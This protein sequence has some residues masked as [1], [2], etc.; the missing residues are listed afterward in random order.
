M[1]HIYFI[2][3][4]EIFL[5]FLL[6][7]YIYICLTVLRSLKMRLVYS[8]LSKQRVNKTKISNYFSDGSNIIKLTYLTFKIW[9]STHQS[10][11]YPYVFMSVNEHCCWDNI[12]GQIS[13]VD[14]MEINARISSLIVHMLT[15]S[16]MKQSK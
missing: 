10:C 12:L 11:S 13:K 6:L 14:R 9:S 3:K 2:Q 16:S 8:F 5:Q 7:F 4:W 1:L 15:S